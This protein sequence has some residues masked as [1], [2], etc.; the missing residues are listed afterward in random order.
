MPDQLTTASKLRFKARLGRL[1][2]NDLK[3]VISAVLFQLDVP[4]VTTHE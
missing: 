1:S 4:E 2:D 3:K